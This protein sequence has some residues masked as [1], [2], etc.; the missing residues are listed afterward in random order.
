MYLL[1]QNKPPKKRFEPVGN[2][3][4]IHV[5]ESDVSHGGVALPDTRREP[6]YMPVATIV[7]AGSDCK[8]L[9][10]CEGRR[11]VF[12]GHVKEFRF[13]GDKYSIIKEDQF[14]VLGLLPDEEN[15]EK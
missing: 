7:A 4:V 10:G 3:V 9:K 1:G 2:F 11:I 5:H 8:Y 15:V 6:V 12:A 14:V 13:Y